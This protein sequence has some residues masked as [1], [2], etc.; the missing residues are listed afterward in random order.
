MNPFL[1]GAAALLPVLVAALVARMTTTPNLAGWYTNLSKPWFNPPDWIFG[2]MWTLLYAMMAY[3]F[4]KVLTSAFSPWTQMAVAAFL[5]QICL[6]AAWS[7]VFFGGHSPRGGLLVIAALW[8]CI[9]LTCLAF[10]QIDHWASMLMWPYLAWVT[11]AAL[12]NVEIHRLNP[13]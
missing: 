9:A 4:F 11:F 13:S 12:L 7:W 8:F 5:V 2:P 3:A 6:N 1:A 10:W